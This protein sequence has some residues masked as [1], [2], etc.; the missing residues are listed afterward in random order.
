[1]TWP[2]QSESGTYT[3]SM[4]EGFE[5]SHVANNLILAEAKARRLYDGSHEDT[6]KVAVTVIVRASLMGQNQASEVQTRNGYDWSLAIDN[7]TAVCMGPSGRFG[8]N[9]DP[10][11]LDPNITSVVVSGYNTGNGR[12]KIT[13]IRSSQ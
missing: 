12:G 2:I 9:G 6:H 5:W 10:G 13:H 1:M 7:I 4:G 8:A 3:Y 11:Q